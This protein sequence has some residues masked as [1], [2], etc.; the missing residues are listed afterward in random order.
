MECIDWTHNIDRTAYVYASSYS[1]YDIGMIGAGSTGAESSVR[2]YKDINNK[3]EHVLL[4]ELKNVN[5]GCFSLD[6]SHK[7]SQMIFTT[8]HHGLYVYDIKRK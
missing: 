5:D 4:S 1:K 7:K 6:F 2:I 3:G 8:A